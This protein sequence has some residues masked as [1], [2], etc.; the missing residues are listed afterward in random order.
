[1]KKYILLI[2]VIGLTAVSAIAQNTFRLSYQIAVPMGETQDFIDQAAFRGFS[3]EYYYEVVDK[4]HAGMEVSWNFFHK[5]YPRQT[6]EFENGAVNIRQWRY[7]HVI[8]VLFNVMYDIHETEKFTVYGKYGL[9]PYWVNDEV[10]AGLLT[11]ADNSAKF[12]MA[13]GIGFTINPTPGLGF[14]FEADYQFIVN[15]QYQLDGSAHSHYWNF[16]MGLQFGK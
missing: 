13:P 7:K 16:K 8:P 3:F 14:N 1:M 6:Y 12:G 10:W 2:A 15:G 9:G 4:V 11:I 5:E